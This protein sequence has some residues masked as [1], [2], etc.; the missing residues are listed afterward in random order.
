[1]AQ[2]IVVDANIAVALAIAT[3]YSEQATGLMEGWRR[4]RVPL[5]AP[6]LWEYELA[7]AMRKAATLGLLTGDEAEAALAELLR[8]RIERV[9]PEVGLH[10]QALR[11]AARLN[12]TVAYDGQY[13]AVAERLGA[14]F[15]TAD[16]RLA[17][18]AT[19]LGISWVRSVSG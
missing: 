7:S 8:L 13:L 12:Q 5:Y 9:A 19:A 1:M 6:L 16:R 2:P 14:T 3:P 4:D 15:H 11:W 18:A 10:R 17:E